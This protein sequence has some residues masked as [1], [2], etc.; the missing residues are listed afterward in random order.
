MKNAPATVGLDTE[1]GEK[2]RQQAAEVAFKGI[3]EIEIIVRDQARLGVLH[4]FDVL[5]NGGA[6]Q[7]YEFPILRNRRELTYQRMLFPAP[8]TKSGKELVITKVKRSPYAHDCHGPIEGSYPSSILGMYYLE[9]T[10]LQSYYAEIRTQY[11]D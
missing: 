11:Y 9:E 2:G 1:L 6:Y 3:L 10:T 5:D 8:A 7:Q 4:V